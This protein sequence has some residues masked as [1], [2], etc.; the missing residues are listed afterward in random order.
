MN[1][2][3]PGLVAQISGVLTTKRYKCATVFVDQGSRLGYVHLQKSSSAEETIEA[4]EAW[5]A[6][7]RTHGVTVKAYHA[8][9]GIFRANKWVESCRKARQ[10]LTFAGVNSHHENGIAERRIKEIQ[11]GARTMLIHANR[12]WKSNVNA[13]LWPYAVRMASD[14]VNVM[15]NMQREDRRT[16]MQVF[17]GTDIHGN[18]K[19]WHHFGS[20]VFVLDQDLQTNAPFGKWKSRA[21]IGIYLGRSP[22]HSRNVA[23]VLSILTGLVSPQFH[24]KHDSTFNTVKE[25]KQDTPAPWMVKAGFVGV[26]EEPSDRGSKRPA[27][28]GKSQ[29]GKQRRTVKNSRQQEGEESPPSRNGAETA[30]PASGN[31]VGTAPPAN[32]AHRAPPWLTLPPTPANEAEAMAPPFPNPFEDPNEGFDDTNVGLSVTD[33]NQNEPDEPNWEPTRTQTVKTRSGR[34]SRANPRYI[35]AMLVQAMVTDVKGR[36]GDVEGEIFCYEALFPEDRLDKSDPLMIYK[37]TSDP[38]TMYMHQA[39]R[40]PDRDEFKK[41]MVKEVTDQMA[42][43][44]FSIVERTEVPKG[45]MIMPTVWQMKRKRDIKTREIKKWKARLNIDGSK[46]VKGQHYDESY[47]PVVSWNSIRTMLI[48]AAQFNWHTVQLDYVLAFPQAPIEKTLYM[49]VPKGFEIDG[50]DRRVHVLKLHKNVYG[51]KNA[52]RTWYQYLTKKLIEEVGFTQSTVD[53]CVF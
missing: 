6:Y 39:M 27:K 49:E 18:V 28:G 26:R 50:Y 5:E 29:A 7:A 47:S 1:S 11:E 48:L 17:T 24:V 14:Q 4:K 31:G 40:E 35:E 43:G 8:D 44:N 37:A 42:N 30:P 23:L 2:A 45:Q 32:N 9:N 13:H 51:S 38:D 3:T 36:G 10:P 34:T 52:G 19:H 53:E 46:M 33:E 16:P 12:R 41:A 20:P 21:K 22:Q 25:E 15:P